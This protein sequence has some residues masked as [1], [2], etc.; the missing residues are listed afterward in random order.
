MINNEIIIV[1]GGLAGL[2]AGIHLRKNNFS[3][4]I[5]EKNEFP[6]HKVCGE[7]ISNEVLPYLKSLELDIQSLQPKNINKLSFSL[8]SGKTINVNLPLGGFGLSRYELD[9]YLYKEAKKL[10]CQIIHESVKNIVFKND[11]FQ[12]I[13]LNN[14]FSSKVVLGAFGKRSNLDVKLKRN[15]IQN[16]SNWLSV[17]AHYNLDFPDNLVGLHHFKG[18]YCGVSKVENNL[19]NICYLANYETFKKY[20]SIEEYQENIIYENPNLKEIFQKAKIQFEKPLTISQISFDEKKCVENHVLMIGDTAGLIHPLCGNGM[21]MAIHSAKIASENVID[22]L[23]NKTSREQLES[24]YTKQWNNNFKK[25]L[26]TGRQIGKLVQ[27]EKLAQ[28]MMKLLLI[29]PSLLPSIIKKTHGK[30]F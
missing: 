2:I 4:L 13:T 25:R 26:K 22:Y 12:V 10:G 24:N 14:N 17:K 18:G 19:V 30:P 11:E 15:F 5:L 6:K 1:G 16:P 27:Q 23:D 8:V 9:F 29:F 7:Y 3:V 28:L 20:K 21:A